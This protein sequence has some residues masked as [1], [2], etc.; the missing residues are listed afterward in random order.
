MINPNAIELIV[1]L[2]EAGDTLLHTSD[3]DLLLD[4]ILPQ[5]ARL[6][7]SERANVML[8][9]GG[10]LCIVRQQ[11]YTGDLLA[12]QMR[13]A[14]LSPELPPFTQMRAE[15]KP[16]LIPDLTELPQ[17]VYPSSALG[18]RSYLGAP[19][20]TGDELIG[21]L[22]LE[23]RYAG[24]FTRED[25]EL[26]Q[27]F[28][29]LAG[30]AL[31][32]IFYH[33]ESERRQH[34][35]EQ[36]NRITGALNRLFYLDAILESGLEAALAIMGMK[37]GA[38]FIFDPQR[39]R[40]VLRAHHNLAPAAV[41]L[42]RQIPSDY[43]VS[44]RAFTTRQIIV[45]DHLSDYQHK[46]APILRYL[47]GTTIAIP[48]L[49]RGNSIGV[50][51]LNDGNRS[52]SLPDDT[53]ATARTIAD[54]LAFAAQRGQLVKRLQ[55]QLQSARHLYE[56]SSAFLA[57]TNRR[58]VLFIFLR[59]M[60]EI[61]PNTIG[62]ACYHY[63]DGRWERTMLYPSSFVTTCLPQMTEE[64]RTPPYVA[65]EE[66]RFLNVC[67]T[68]K[69]MILINRQQY[70]DLSGWE[71]FAGCNVTQVLYLPLIVPQRGDLT[72]F[73]VVALLRDTQTPPDSQTHA[74]VWAL[75]HQ[76]GATLSRVH[77]YEVIH[78][79]QNRLRAILEASRDG[80]I[81][82]DRKGGIRYINR[83]ALTLCGL[84]EDVSAWERRP[85][86][87]CLKVIGAT[88]NEVLASALRTAQITSEHREE[89]DDVQTHEGRWV[90]VESW[91]VEDPRGEGGRLFVIEDVT[92]A[93]EVE[94]LREDLLHMLIHDLRN[95]LTLVINALQI[96]MTPEL[97]ELHTEAIEL[98]YANAVRLLSMINA[99]LDLTRLRSGYLQIHHQPTDL[100]SLI[101]SQLDYLI[102]PG[103]EVAI[104]IDIEPQAC[105]ACADQPL[106]RRVFQNLLGN[107][108][109]FISHDEN[110]YI[111]IIGKREGDEVR[112]SI[113]NNGE[114]ISEELL[115]NLFQPYATG[116]LYTGGIG[117]GL[118]FCK[119]VIEAHR[120]R[121]WAENLYDENEVVF[122]FTLPAVT[123]SCGR[124]TAPPD[125]NEPSPPPR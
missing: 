21:F 117:L 48:L 1:T 73:D 113:F 82:V 60:K 98:G 39:D 42:L 3:L 109:K 85:W 108:L 24:A 56:A 125:S 11:G 16:L 57:Q 41:E 17:M 26:L 74:L 107:A 71:H 122:H 18:I 14:C 5:L 69:N 47:G 28:A 94:Q 52:T 51:T 106:M 43:G 9:E 31:H 64:G 124:E 45:T 59:A 84:E 55:S 112:I 50:M 95:P 76:V 38:V 37:R 101:R 93:R 123:P 87:E 97:E 19:L 100:E 81:L 27:T 102:P 104:T 58:E 67:R 8:L 86:D 10:E 116:H 49:V 119:M 118:A 70:P 103:R 111:R 15:G 115:P 23:S 80:L 46:E 63:S 121:I 91:Q 99:I 75:I 114:P 92:Q 34:E 12:R 110:G 30:A 4:Q 89:P 40:L 90:N 77:S 35:L 68:Q 20:F 78:E 65:A 6:I 32:N 53:L 66:S 54:Q 25:K 62:V 22:N 105:L 61:V 7:R 2:R 36:M 72:V 13:W 96:Q 79:E 83:R 88:G 44:G 33:R 120:G 29:H